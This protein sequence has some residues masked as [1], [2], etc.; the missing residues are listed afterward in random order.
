MW[1]ISR[2]PGFWQFD[3]TVNGAVHCVRIPVRDFPTRAEAIA[4]RIRQV[5][6]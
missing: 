3:A 2:P 5:G 1:E 6:C 4:E